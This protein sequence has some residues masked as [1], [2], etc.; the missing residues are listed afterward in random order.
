M[1]TVKSDVVVGLGDGGDKLAEQLDKEEPGWKI[2]GKYVSAHT[3]PHLIVA[4]W[5]GHRPSY[6][7][8][9]EDRERKCNLFEGYVWHYAAT[10][11][12]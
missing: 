9:R 5:A 4:S 6:S 12:Q 8:R 7:F 10:L 3:L 11:H 1:R 2:S